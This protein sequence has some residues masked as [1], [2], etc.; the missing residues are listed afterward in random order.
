MSGNEDSA[1]AD[2][3]IIENKAV[4]AVFW[5]NQ[6]GFMQYSVKIKYDSVQEAKNNLQKDAKDLGNQLKT[7]ITD[8]KENEQPE[9]TPGPKKS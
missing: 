2:V 7:S 9:R 4:T 8:L 1:D 6:Y 3:E 5:K